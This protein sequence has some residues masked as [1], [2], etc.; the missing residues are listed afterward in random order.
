MEH[1]VLKETPARKGV[2]LRRAQGCG[3]AGGREAC[4]AVTPGT[5]R[6][7]PGQGHA[8]NCSLY[9]KVSAQVRG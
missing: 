7:A 1:Y 9:S 3:A 6:P 2:L 8:K 4:P 5:D